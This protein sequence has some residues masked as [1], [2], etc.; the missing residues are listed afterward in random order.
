MKKETAT[1]R[2]SKRIY[3]LSRIHSFITWD[4]IGVDP[5][6]QTSRHRLTYE[7]S[8]VY[9]IMD[10]LKMEYIRYGEKFEDKYYHKN[11]KGFLNNLLLRRFEKIN[12][13]KER[14]NERK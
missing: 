4:M 2:I 8:I 14:I 10:N 11:T 6:T 5:Y 9:K 3:E 1:E 13:I 7:G 12:K